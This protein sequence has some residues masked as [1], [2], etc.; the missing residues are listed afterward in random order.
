[1]QNFMHRNRALLLLFIDAC[2]PIHNGS[3]PGRNETWLCL[4]SIVTWVLTWNFHGK[5]LNSQSQYLERWATNSARAGVSS[6][7][8]KETALTK[9]TICYVV[10]TCGPFWGKEDWAN[11]LYNN[12]FWTLHRHG[13]TNTMFHIWSCCIFLLRTYSFLLSFLL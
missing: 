4:K 12:W 6:C 9:I 7:R 8:P 1:M 5:V 13:N 3:K 11:I 10:D 2:E